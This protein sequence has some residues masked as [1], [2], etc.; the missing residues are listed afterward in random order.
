MRADGKDWTKGPNGAAQSG[1]AHYVPP[2][3]SGG[4][5]ERN[6]TALHGGERRLL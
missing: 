2:V 4:G 5:G 6:S 3:L 1:D